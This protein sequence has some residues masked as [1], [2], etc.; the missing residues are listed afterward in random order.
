MSMKRAFPLI[1]GLWVACR[2]AAQQV[3]EEELKSVDREVVFVNYEGPQQRI[4]TA[5]EIKG[6]GWYLAS[7]LKEGG[8]RAS[9]LLKYSVIRAVD[10][11]ETGRFDADILSIDADAKVD[12]IDNVRRI[13]AGYLEGAFGYSAEDAHTLA[14][15]AT[16]YNAVY[17]GRL[18]Y[19]GGKYKRVVMSYLS[20]QNAGL[21]TKYYEW[22][23]ASRILIPLTT[24][25]ATGRLS[26]LSTSELS[27]KAVVEEMRKAP[28]MGLEDRKDMVELKERE[29]EEKQQ[30]VEESKQELAQAR[31]ELAETKEQLAAA[32]APEQK[33]A[34]QAELTAKEQEVK[35]AEQEVA[36][37]EQEVRG[38][39]AE[40]AE[41]RKQIISDEISRAQAEGERPGT[42]PGSFVFSDQLYYLRVR[43]RESS[44]SISGTVSILDP[45]LGSVKVTSPVGY[46]RGRAFYFFQ[47]AILVVGHESGP[48][49]P[50][51]LMLLDPL[52]LVEAKRSAEEVYRDSYVLL[53][54]G[55]IYAVVRRGSEHRLGRFDTQLTLTALSD[56]AVDADSSIAL[57]GDRIY[58]NSASRQ[59]VTLNRSTLVQEGTVR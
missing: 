16:V 47:D 34:L 37:K 27:E 57:F 5:E 7:A 23:G 25:A 11:E 46:V 14:V 2:L 12:H 52:S 22:P 51:R 40:I 13:L 43:E 29:V 24:E 18:D 1:L 17:R 30:E 49:S 38:K 58:L 44:G 53:Q 15:F 9:F 26:S 48:S 4:D 56:L 32:R 21:S 45:V 41:E 55:S 54:A 10:P 42:A 19:L 59:V 35:R 33:S 6:L 28:D 36:A 31:Q 20:A 3:A 39:E 8:R 50:A